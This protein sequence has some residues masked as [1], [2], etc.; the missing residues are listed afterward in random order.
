M[1][2]CAG[3]ENILNCYETY[4]KKNRYFMVV[5]IMDYALNS[6]LSIFE[7]GLEENVIKYHSK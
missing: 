6:I 2:M 3:E 7:R 1:K 5:E 4:Q